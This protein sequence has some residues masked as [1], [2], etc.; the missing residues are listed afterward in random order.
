MEAAER[1]R[2]RKLKR[3][4]VSKD[5]VFPFASNLGI[6]KPVTNKVLLSVLGLRML[7][8]VKI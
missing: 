2:V 5:L 1:R 3:E 6:M 7:V 8:G 4:S